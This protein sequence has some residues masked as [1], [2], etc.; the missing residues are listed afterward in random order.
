MI[1]HI[2]GRVFSSGCGVKLSAAAAPDKDGPLF[3]SMN[4]PMFV[5]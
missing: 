3:V 4:V 5:L 2:L 1:S